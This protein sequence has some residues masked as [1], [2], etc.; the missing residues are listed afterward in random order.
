M[1]STEVL[2]EKV[3]SLYGPQQRDN[4]EKTTNLAIIYLA[5]IIQCTDHQVKGKLKDGEFFSYQFSISAFPSGKSIAL[6]RRYS[7]LKLL[8][9]CI[10]KDYPTL[11][12]PYL[13]T[14]INS[15]TASKID[16]RKRNLA[17]WIEYVLNLPQLKSYPPIVSYFS[18]CE[19]VTNPEK[20][21]ENPPYVVEIYLRNLQASSIN[22]GK[23]NSM[24]SGVVVQR[25]CQIISRFVM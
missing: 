12:V 22:C 4:L 13:P 6:E 20:L 5:Q 25:S 24:T 15:V 18:S 8:Q 2:L 14:G 23:E 19:C 17:M 21:M 9:S 11:L 1:S 3:H 16:Y 10:E 7:D